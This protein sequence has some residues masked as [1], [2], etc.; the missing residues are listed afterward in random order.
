[1]KTFLLSMAAAA[2]LT[3]V[4]APASAQS[5][6]QSD[7][8]YEQPY[9]RDHVSINQ[10]QERL[11]RRLERGVMR[12][13]L[14]RNEARRLHMQAREVAHLE[15]RYRVN[16]LNSWER[17]D[18]D[19]RFDRLEAMVRFERRDGDNRRD[20]GRRDDDDRRYARRDRD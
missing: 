8:R 4:A 18:L 14:T 2:A 11:E 17:A 20:Y 13:D 12:G 10:R 1:M 9:G 15:A 19:R 7:R 5:Y 3:A 16:G 6:D